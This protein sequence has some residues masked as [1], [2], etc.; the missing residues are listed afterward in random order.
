MYL[1]VLISIILAVMHTLHT[2]LIRLTKYND[3]QSKKKFELLLKMEWEKA[4]LYIFTYIMLFLHFC[5]VTIICSLL[6]QVQ[7]ILSSIYRVPID[8]TWKTF[9]VQ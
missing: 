9:L 3:Y 8:D 5:I 1:P 2:H 7:I 6:D 4:N